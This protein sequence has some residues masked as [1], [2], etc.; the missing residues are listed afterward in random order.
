MCGC[1]VKTTTTRE[2][3]TPVSNAQRRFTFNVWPF[4]R[5]VTLRLMSSSASASRSLSER[6]LAYRYAMLPAM[7]ATPVRVRP[8]LGRR[9]SLDNRRA[10][11][12]VLLVWV[13]NC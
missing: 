12:S 13:G 2:L 7:I 3:T 5:D 4:S 9:E 11:V 6:M 10:D 1:V 8:M